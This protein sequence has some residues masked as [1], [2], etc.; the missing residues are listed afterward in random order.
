MIQ[1]R[2]H[3]L[4]TLETFSLKSPGYKLLAYINSCISFFLAELYIGALFLL[5]LHHRQVEKILP[6]A[7]SLQDSIQV[8]ES[9]IIDGWE[10]GYV[11]DLASW[12]TIKS[13]S[14]T[15]TPLGCRLFQP[16]NCQLILKT[17][18]YLSWKKKRIG[19]L[20]I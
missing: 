10:C 9:C 5:Q 8:G 4:C 17:L 18:C 20:W 3:S 7:K 13:G 1:I 11:T 16:Q 14:N 19:R 2:I 6:N 12:E 15:K